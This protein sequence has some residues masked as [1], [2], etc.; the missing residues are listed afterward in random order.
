MVVCGLQV[1]P[2]G[3]KTIAAGSYHSMVLKQDGSVWATGQNNCGQLGDGTTTQRSSF[4]QVVR[5]Y[6]VFINVGGAEGIAAGY[7]H[8]MVLKDGSV[9]ATGRNNFG[10]LGLEKRK[11]L[12]HSFVRVIP[13]GVQAVATGDWD[14]MVLKQDGSLWATGSN[15]YGQLGDGST[16]GKNTFVRA[17]LSDDG[18]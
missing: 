5:R 10:Q 15:S 9:W 16:T 3:A 8:S 7:D 4:V 11:A 18:A 2:S 6:S 1:I 12:S 13:S 14:T 17:T